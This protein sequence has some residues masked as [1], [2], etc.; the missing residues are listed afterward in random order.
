MYRELNINGPKE[1]LE[2][3][4]YSYADCFERTKDKWWPDVGEQWKP[5][6]VPREIMKIYLKQRVMYYDML[7]NVKFETSIRSCAKKPEGGFAVRSEH[8][9]TG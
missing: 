9:P 8:L 6:Y 2:Y 4:D 1:K 7:K 3:P 5:S